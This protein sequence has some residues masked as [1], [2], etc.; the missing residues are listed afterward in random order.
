[1]FRVSFPMSSVVDYSAFTVSSG[2]S[3]R[4][5]DGGYVY[6]IDH[7]GVEGIV[8]ELVSVFMSATDLPDGFYLNYESGIVD[9]LNSDGS[10]SYSANACRS[11]NMESDGSLIKE[12]ES[13]YGEQTG[14]SLDMQMY[15]FQEIG[16]EPSAVRW[17]EEY[18]RNRVGFE[19]GN[20]FGVL[21]QLDYIILNSDRSFRNI[22]FRFG[23][24]GSRG[25][26]KIFDNGKSLFNTRGALPRSYAEAKE[27]V[28][29]RVFQPF[30]NNP[31]QG[32]L[33][34][35]KERGPAF[36]VDMDSFRERVGGLDGRIRDFWCT[37]F[38]LSRVEQLISEFPVI[39]SAGL[40]RTVVP[41]M[42]AEPLLGKRF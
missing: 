8:E 33:Y 27:M 17:V 6:K 14:M 42:R 11:A 39:S 34:F 21:A 15:R 5:Y 36:H 3:L 41:V 26:S 7:Y 2:T 35:L 22:A 32:F 38:L 29:G 23:P 37:H 4:V 1:M 25:W 13:F 30:F 40:S 24:D 31:R 28:S 9:V 10:I 19:P 18:V 12:M 20:M 16:E